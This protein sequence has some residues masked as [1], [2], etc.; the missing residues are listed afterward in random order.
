MKFYTLRDFFKWVDIVQQ[1]FSKT[2]AAK[3]Q[4]Q[5]STRLDCGKCNVA[6]LIEFIKIHKCT[7]QTILIKVIF[8][9]L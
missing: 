8:F 2:A 9:F 7:S 3:T 5:E 1:S 6:S 4:T